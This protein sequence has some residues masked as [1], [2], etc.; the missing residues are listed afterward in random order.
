M[1]IWKT[2]K[3][4]CGKNPFQAPPLNKEEAQ[5]L[6]NLRNTSM[7]TVNGRSETL[8]SLIASLHRGKEIGG[9]KLTDDDF[10]KLLKVSFLTISKAYRVS[11]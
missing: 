10:P 3:L 7:M 8:L 9:K 11:E 5:E 6:W 1:Q 2:H 4:V